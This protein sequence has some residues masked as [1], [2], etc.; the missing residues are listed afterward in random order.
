MRKALDGTAEG[1]CTLPTG[2]ICEV[3]AHYKGECP[4]GAK[5][6]TEETASTTETA[7]AE[8]E[9]P[10]IVTSTEMAA[11]S[12]AQI[13]KSDEETID[14]KPKPKKVAS[15]GEIVL[16]AEPGEEPGEIVTSWKT[17]DAADFGYI[18]MLS[19]NDQIEYP[20]KYFHALKNPESH[21][22]VWTGLVKDK[23]YYFRVCLAEGESCGEYSSV[24]SAVAQ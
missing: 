8:T 3:W 6:N 7:V 15:A 14:D 16:V 21:S 22:F 10:R 20:T 12:T 1:M 9:M 4:K 23:T 11:S 13:A 24:V 18:V 19:G 17:D 2:I 5:V